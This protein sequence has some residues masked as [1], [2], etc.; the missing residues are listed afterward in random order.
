MI[1]KIEI[2]FAQPVELSDEL[3]EK[4]HDVVDEVCKTYVAEHP[5]RTMWLM[6]R[7]NKPIWNEPHEPTFDATVYHIDVAERERYKDDTAAQGTGDSS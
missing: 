7:G 4:L 1:L 6:G 2:E 5:D 3:K